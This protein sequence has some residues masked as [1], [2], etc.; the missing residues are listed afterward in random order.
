MN[1]TTTRN[2]KKPSRK[3]AVSTS[4]KDTERPQKGDASTSKK[5]KP[6]QSSSAAEPMSPK[7]KP[8]ASASTAHSGQADV[9]MSKQDQIIAMLRLSKGATLA[10]LMAVTGWQ[11]HSVRGVI[12]AVLKKKL[13][14][15]V[16]S[17][18]S[19][20]GH[21]RYRIAEIESV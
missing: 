14:L 12:S 2:V 11:A 10:D 1:T 15:N 20:K 3:L 7:A 5:V 19:P 13:S 8:L 18:L 16:I 4:Q 9:G 17:E 21:R 6:V